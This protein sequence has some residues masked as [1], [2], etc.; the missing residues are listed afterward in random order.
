[1]RSR[2][3]T[4]RSSSPSPY[5]AHVTPS[6]PEAASRLR[7]RYACQSRSASM[8]CNRLVNFC[9]ESF[10]AASR[11][12]SSPLDADD[13]PCV[14][15]AVACPEFPLATGLFST[16][17]ADGWP[18]FIGGAS[19]F[20][21]FIDTI[22]VSDFPSADMPEYSHRPFPTAPIHGRDRSHPGSPGF[23]AES[24]RTCPGSLT[25][26]VRCA[27]CDNATLRAAFP[28]KS[29][30]RRPKMGD[31]GARSPS[32]NAPCQRFAATLTS[33]RRMTRGHGW[34]LTFAL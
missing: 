33:G 29:Q 9:F 28:I 32:L 25:P 21:R 26:W 34:S 30:G 4:R 12:L 18:T 8:W 15:L 17:S 22:P 11:I 13:G 24:L 27:A 16:D 5:S 31:F 7:Q 14:P 20:I 19:W 2:R 1:M 23:R 6:T 10:L 3:S